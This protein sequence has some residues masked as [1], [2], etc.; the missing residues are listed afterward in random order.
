MAYPDMATMLGQEHQEAEA[1]WQ[2]AFPTIDPLDQTAE[3]DRLLYPEVATLTK[4]EKQMLR[5][6]HRENRI[7]VHEPV[8]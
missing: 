8:A 6:Q 4:C 7:N 3:P 2:K 1:N 5:L